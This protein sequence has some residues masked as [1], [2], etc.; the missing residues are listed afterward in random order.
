MADVSFADYYSNLDKKEN[1]EVW[2][3]ES[4]VDKE[5]IWPSVP[6][7][8]NQDLSKR[9]NIYTGEILDMKKR[10]IGKVPAERLRKLHEIPDF[11]RFIKKAKEYQDYRKKLLR[12]G[13]E[14][15]I[16]NSN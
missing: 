8:Y 14:I 9:L 6:F 12:I 4:K 3:I 1:N 16:L 2:Y 10:N 15:L 11:Q 5:D 13:K 7:G